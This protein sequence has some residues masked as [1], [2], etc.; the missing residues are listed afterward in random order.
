[1]EMY[2]EN[3]RHLLKNL[4]LRGY[5]R[6]IITQAIKKARKLDR[7]TLLMNNKTDHQNETVP[8]ILTNNPRNPDA[9][10]I[11]KKHKYLLDTLPGT[12]M[13][14]N[15]RIISVVRKP[16]SIRN[17]LVKS[18]LIQN[19]KEKGSYPCTKNCSACEFLNNKTHLKSCATG[20]TF[21][22]RGSYN[23]E[24]TSVI[25]A[26]TCK[27]CQIQ[28]IGQTGNSIRERLYG[29]TNDI[30]AGNDV[31]PVARHFSDAGHT[32][33]D[34]DVTVLTQTIRNLNYRL[35]TEE[36]LI[37]YFKTKQP[38]GLNLIQ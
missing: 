28:Y 15:T 7:N 33:R 3:S 2:D 1:M 26:I 38:H 22:I 35:R 19:N 29:H 10:K 36:S 37:H 32:R 23:C 30:R 34:V 4:T 5:P 21:T 31:K 25:Y 8:L 13:F 12:E 6:R 16:L 11:L 24:T 27:K 17:L 20:K 18:D 14:K 9:S